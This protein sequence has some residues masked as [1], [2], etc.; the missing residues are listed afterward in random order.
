MNIGRT[1]QLNGFTADVYGDGFCDVVF[2]EKTAE[3]E[4]TKKN[5]NSQGE[6]P[7]KHPRLNVLSI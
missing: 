6:N 7:H 1:F 5:K 3:N 4:K 2:V